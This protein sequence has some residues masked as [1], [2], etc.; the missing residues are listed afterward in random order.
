M[1]DAL[2][3]TTRT[4]SSYLGCEV[5]YLGDVFPFLLVSLIIGLSI[6]NDCKCD[7]MHEFLSR[8]R[9]SAISF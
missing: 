2:F 5:L 6:G 4:I 9:D 8:V 1:I 7:C 3:V